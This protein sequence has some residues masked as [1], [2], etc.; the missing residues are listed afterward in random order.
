[1]PQIN[2]VA[3]Q[4]VGLPLAGPESFSQQQLDYLKR[5]L[6]VDETVLW[7]NTSG[8][9]T[10]SGSLSEPMSNFEYIVFYAINNDNQCVPS[11]RYH[12]NSTFL[13]SISGNLG[14][15]IGGVC[16]NTNGTPLIKAAQLTATNSTWSL[17]TTV[18]YVLGNTTKT[19]DMNR[20]WPS[21]IVGIHRISGGN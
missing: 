21:R 8:T 7:E 9:K 4:L 15:S 6:G 18:D 2:S 11:T 1:M 3:G 5:A 16:F 10:T 20:C 12:V 17:V 14:V 19:T 13:S